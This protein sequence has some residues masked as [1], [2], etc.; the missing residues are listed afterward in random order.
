MIMSATYTIRHAYTGAAAYD[1]VAACTKEITRAAA[2]AAMLV[3]APLLGLAFVIALPLAGLAAIAW[4]LVKAVARKRAV[5]M[6]VAKRTVLF[7]A[8]PFVGLA[9]L[10]AFPFVA[11]GMLGYYAIRKA[12][13]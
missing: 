5:A 3:A 12:P 1:A 2:T 6:A 9:Y 8:A 4:M 13:G 10:M 7:F 11:I